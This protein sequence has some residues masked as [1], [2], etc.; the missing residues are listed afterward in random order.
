MAGIDNNTNYLKVNYFI[1]MSLF[2]TIRYFIKNETLFSYF[3]CCFKK[4][5]EEYRFE[6]TIKRGLEQ[7]EKDF[8]IKK[9]IDLF[10]KSNS[11]LHKCNHEKNEYYVPIDLAV[12]DDDGLFD[13]HAHEAEGNNVRQSLATGVNNNAQ[14]RKFDDFSEIE[15]HS[16]VIPPHHN[17]T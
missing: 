6:R 3:C 16:S 15:D 12:E 13:T 5:S 9:L 4:S 11:S 10:H 17:M 7:L 8:N 2:N 1:N 14:A